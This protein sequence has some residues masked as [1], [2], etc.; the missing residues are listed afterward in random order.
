MSH[1]AIVA[2]D[3]DGTLIRSDGTVSERTRRALRRVREQGGTVVFV[4]GRPIRVMAEVVALTSVSGI[5]VCANGALVY[6]LDAGA[7]LRNWVLDPSAALRL[8]LAIREIVPDAAFAVESG[9]KFGREPLFRTM[10][11]DPHEL[12]ADLAELVTVLPPVKL[13]VRS[14]G[15]SLADVYEKVV[16]L[17][18]ADAAVTRSTETLI[19]IAGAGV[20]KAV[21]LAEVAASRGVSADEVV[22]FG[23]MLNDLPMLAWAGHSVAVAN[24]HADVLAAA[25]EVTASNDNDGVAVVLERLFP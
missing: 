14:G 5:A 22:A 4:T 8:G 6:D 19:E 16:A 17:A 12:V 9:L 21:A 13:L 1:P 24:A 25:D 23:D 20:S 7:T 10:W 15:E 2:T 3:L 18:G 11:P